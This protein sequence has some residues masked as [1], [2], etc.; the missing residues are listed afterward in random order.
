M[1]NDPDATVQ[2]CS[3]QSPVAHWNPAALLQAWAPPS[4]LAAK[5][6]IF[7][8]FGPSRQQHAL[9]VEGSSPLQPTKT[10][11]A[12]FASTSHE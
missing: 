5:R 1:L 2:V 3:L 9:S 10:P 7:E 12:H 6:L 11:P 8:P 4:Q